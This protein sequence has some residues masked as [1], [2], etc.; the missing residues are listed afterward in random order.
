MD[1][2]HDYLPSKY[3]PGTISVDIIKENG[4]DTG[5]QFCSSAEDKNVQTELATCDVGVQVDLPL[6][7]AENLEGNDEKTKFYTGIINFGTFMLLFNSIAKV[8]VKLNYWQGKDSLKE[9]SYLADEG[10]QKP[11]PKRKMRLIDEFLLVMMRL[12]LG[13]LRLGLSRSFLRL[14]KYSVPN[15][16][17]LV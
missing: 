11:G 3:C 5:S 14:N 8:A 1:S 7:T 16:N 4:T 10:K 17:Y 9:K 12:R 2:F 13:L 15:P 6:L